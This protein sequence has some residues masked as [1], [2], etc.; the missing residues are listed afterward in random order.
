M[1]DAVE[2][3]GIYHGVVENFQFML[4]SWLP[5]DHQVIIEIPSL[6]LSLSYLFMSLHDTDTQDTAAGT[7]VELAVVPDHHM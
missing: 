3:Q 7:A 5:C 4:D 2:R 1:S 6:Y